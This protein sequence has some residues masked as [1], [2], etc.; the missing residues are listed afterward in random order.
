[1]K[2]LKQANIFFLTFAGLLTFALAVCGIVFF[3]LDIKSLFAEPAQ[4]ATKQETLTD[5]PLQH[6]DMSPY[7]HIEIPGVGISEDIYQHTGDANFFIDHD[8]SGN[9]NYKGEIFSQYPQKTDFSDPVTVLYGH[10]FHVN[11]DKFSNLWKYRDATFCKEHPDII[12][13]SDG[14]T[15]TYKII[16]TYVWDNRNILETFDFSNQNTRLAYFDYILHPEDE[17][18]VVDMESTLDWRRDKILQLS[19]CVN[20]KD[21]KSS[22]FIVSAKLVSII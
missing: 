21:T 3:D 1:M 22:R 4:P 17:A 19:T 14:K 10:N 11:T 18:A 15:Y 5:A 9:K 2:K 12:I 20:A 16:S 13:T 6:S 7:A 8:S